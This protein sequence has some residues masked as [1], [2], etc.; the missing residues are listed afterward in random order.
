M[1]FLRREDTMNILALNGSPRRKGNTSHLLSEF[2]RGAR[3]AGARAEELRA[4]E[5][6]L[7]YCRGCLRCNVLKRCSLTNDDW[8]ELSAKILAADV[9]VFA[10]PVYFH[11]LSAP[12]KK[13][14]DRF[15]SF[16]HVQITAEGLRHT[17]WQPWNKQLVLLLSLGSS[18]DDDARPIRDLFDFLAG[19]LGPGTAVSPIAGTRLAVANQVA[20]D[21]E[22]LRALYP[23]I[24]LPETLA[25]EDYQRNRALLQKCYELGRDLAQAGKQLGPDGR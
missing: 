17:P 13:I 5:L 10:S 2:F 7:K 18:R 21:A 4:E 20:M 14:L 1:F 12:L 22:E 15:R 6:N 8:P 3:E 23:K 24:G 16:I 9:L 25:E 11:H 19:V